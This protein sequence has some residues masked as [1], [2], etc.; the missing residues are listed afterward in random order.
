M[1]LTKVFDVRDSM[2]Q[3]TVFVTELGHNANEDEK[4]ATAYAGF[5]DN[6]DEQHRYHIFYEPTLKNGS[7]DV[8]EWYHRRTEFCAFSFIKDRFDVLVP[9]QIIDV[10]F[11]LAE[12]E[13]SKSGHISDQWM[14]GALLDNAQCARFSSRSPRAR[15]S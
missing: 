13:V 8:Y 14:H 12:T 10:E 4:N 6:E 15:E 1:P 2:T 11:L 3:M 7:H 9:G 5:T